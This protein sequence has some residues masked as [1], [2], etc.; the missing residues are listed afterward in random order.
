MN[1]EL[2]V[3]KEITV[4]IKLQQ[5]DSEIYHIE[6]EKKFKPLEI[7]KLRDSLSSMEAELSK[8]Q[9][10]LKS[11]QTKH[12][13]KELE[14][15]VSEGEISKLQKQLYQIK[16]NKEYTTMLNEIERRKADK[17]ILEEEVL[18]LIDEIDIANNRLSDEKRLLVEEKKVIDAKTA[19]IESQIREMESSLSGF[20]EKRDRIKP[21]V[22]PDILANYERLL[23]GKEGL[24]LVEVVNDTC[25]G[26]YMALPPQVINEIRKMEKIVNCENCQR[27]FHI[28]NDSAN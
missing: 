2:S 12:K 16:T 9:D 28:K 3:S 14:L 18:K 8:A 4:L 7:K 17:S 20:K 13:S 19:D 6:A 5:I 11:V 24:A 27:I 23:I 25:G 10:E 15:E 21:E 1:N 22:N 26:C